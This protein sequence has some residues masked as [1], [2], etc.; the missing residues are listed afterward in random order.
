MKNEKAVDPNRS[1]T[2]HEL[3]HAMA[4]PGFSKSIRANMFFEA[5]SN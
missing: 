2:L 3:I 5:L 1:R 4:S